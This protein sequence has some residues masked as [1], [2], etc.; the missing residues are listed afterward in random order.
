MYNG[1]R[2]QGF[3]LA[4][5]QPPSIHIPMP[6]STMYRPHQKSAEDWNPIGRLK[7][8]RL[9]SEV[10]LMC[11]VGRGQ[12]FGMAPSHRHPSTILGQS[13]QCISPTKKHA[14]DWNPIGRL[15]RTK[16]D[17]EVGSMYN[18]GRGQGFGWA[19]FP[20]PSIHPP[21][22]AFTMYQPHQKSAEDWNP[23]G[24]LKRGKLDSEVG[25]MCNVG[26]GQGFVL[27]PFQ[28]PSIHF[29]MSESTMSQPHKKNM[30]RTGQKHD[31]DWNPMER[32]K[33]KN[34]IPK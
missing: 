32:L 33:L 11:N 31:E 2:G 34:W 22:P 25:L 3:G 20:P 18:G 8:K 6:A 1:G 19:P 10:G 24:R 4:A 27:A 9:D 14:E 21:M 30:L 7:R 12:G 29:P 15:K 23:I 26:R 28:P 16:L 13:P 5:F 17:P